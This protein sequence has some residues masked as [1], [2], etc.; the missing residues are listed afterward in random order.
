MR[1]FHCKPIFS[2]RIANIKTVHEEHV[3]E[4]MAPLHVEQDLK[5]YIKPN[6]TILLHSVQ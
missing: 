1:Q 4:L 6:I 3:Y 2:V 5:L